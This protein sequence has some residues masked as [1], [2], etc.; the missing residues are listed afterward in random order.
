MAGLKA[1]NWAGLKVSRMAEMKVESWA[2]QRV[3]HWAGPTELKM[4]DRKAGW[5][6]EPSGW[7]LAEQLVVRWVV[8]WA[9]TTAKRK[10]ESWALHSAGLTAT[11]LA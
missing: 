8:R 2:V 7:R 11:S 1:P 6:A 9:V 5:M 4:G 3:E 10:V